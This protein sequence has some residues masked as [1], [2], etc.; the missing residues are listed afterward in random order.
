MARIICT[1][2]NASLNI[3]GIEFEPREEG[4][5][6]SKAD[7]PAEVAE[8]FARI[9][10][11]ALELK[12]GRGGRKSGGEGVPASGG[13][14]E[15]TGNTS[16]Q[17]PAGGQEEPGDG[18]GGEEQS[19]EQ[20]GETGSGEASYEDMSDEQLAEAYQAAFGK[21]PGRAGRD[22]IINKLKEAAAR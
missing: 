17:Q 5:V 20:N 15:P 4:G 1:L 22:T 8:R 14:A 6:I 13:N 21:K 11:Y 9:P 12:S 2:P 18:E 16:E 3:S 10:G 19:G 7:V